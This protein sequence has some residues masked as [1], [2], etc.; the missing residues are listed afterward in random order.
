MKTVILA[1][2]S[3]GLGAVVARLAVERGYKPVIGY[4]GNHERARK[5]AEELKAPTVAG[6][7]AEDAVRA[8]LIEAARSAGEL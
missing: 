8:R 4:R 6:D 5:L 3:G 2:G 1:G 7:L